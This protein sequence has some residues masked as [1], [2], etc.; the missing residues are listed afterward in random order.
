MIKL[1]WII[2]YP[3]RLPI[4]VLII[5]MARIIK[6]VAATKKDI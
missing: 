4:A 2:T 6:A 1:L 3:I 5:V